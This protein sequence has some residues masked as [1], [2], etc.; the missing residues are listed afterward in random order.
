MF[1]EIMKL[2][3]IVGFIIVQTFPVYEIPSNHV[4]LL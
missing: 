3:K 4:K 1:I 2:Y